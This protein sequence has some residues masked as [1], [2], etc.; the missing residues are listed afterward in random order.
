MKSR[1]SPLGVVVDVPH[2]L[3]VELAGQVHLPRKRREPSATSPV[4]D[5]CQSSNDGIRTAEDTPRT[6]TNSIEPS[7]RTIGVRMASIRSP[8][9]WNAVTR[10][11]AARPQVVSPQVVERLRP[12]SARTPVPARRRPP[13]R[14]PSDVKTG[15]NTATAAAREP[16]SWWSCHR[17]ATRSAGRSRATTRASRRATMT[18]GSPRPAGRRRTTRSPVSMTTASG[19]RRSEHVRRAGAR[20]SPPRGERPRRRPTP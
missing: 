9:A 1:H 19:P 13:R 2:A 15:E 11:P 16:R 17:A 12:R 18:G 6:T 8:V 20:L 10:A 14:C 5:T 7:S 3:P 4:G